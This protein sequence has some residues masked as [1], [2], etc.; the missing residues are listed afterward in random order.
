MPG[1]CRAAACPQIQRRDWSCSSCGSERDVA[2]IEERLCA[3]LQQV[4]R[5]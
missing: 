4:G 5:L 1:R 3:M 2:A